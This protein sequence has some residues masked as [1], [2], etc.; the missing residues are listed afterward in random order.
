MNPRKNRVDSNQTV[1]LEFHNIH[2]FKNVIVPLFSAKLNEFKL[3]NSKKEKDFND[4]VI[5]VNIYYYGYHTIPEGA[6]L[7]R[8][9]TSQWNNFR[10]SSNKILRSSADAEFNSADLNLTTEEQAPLLN[11]QHFID[12]NEK[13]KLLSNNPSPYTIK[14][15]II[16]F[17]DTLNL[18]PDKLK[19][20][21]IDNKNNELVFSSI[22]ECSRILEIERYNIKKYLLNGGIYKNYRFKFHTYNNFDRK[23]G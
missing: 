19:I 3:L 6:S 17:R 16:F 2:F 1:T 10:L 20:I 5:L 14:D 13:Y 15:G 21:C 22:S 7:A 23:G 4:W 11:S 8:E 12:F 18:V 9:I